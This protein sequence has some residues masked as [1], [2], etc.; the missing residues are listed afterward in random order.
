[1]QQPR[2]ILITSALTYANGEIHLGH[3]LEAIQTD[4]WKR[5]QLMCGNNCYYICGSDAHGAPIML[6][7]EKNN[8]APEKLVAQVRADHITDY[9][10]F[11]I[12][13]DNFYTTH[14]EENRE[15]SI[16]IYERLK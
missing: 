12:S 3:L 4:I 1:M 8:L 6:A 2:N 13:F 5:F 14:S 15:L 11:H 9:G 10:K 7:A 16:A